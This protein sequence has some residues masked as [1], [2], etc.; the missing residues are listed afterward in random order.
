[1]F[2]PVCFLDLSHYRSSPLDSLQ[3]PHIFPGGE[4]PKLDTAL[5]CTSYQ[6]FVEAKHFMCHAESQGSACL[7]HIDTTLFAPIYL[8]IH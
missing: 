3:L 4:C 2:Q 5:Q 7:S 6:C 8:V 1:M